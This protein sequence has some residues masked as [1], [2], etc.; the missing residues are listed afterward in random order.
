MITIGECAF[1]QCIGLTS[2]TIPDSVTT[3]GR[4]AFFDDRN[5]NYN[6]SAS[7]S[8]WGAKCVNGYVENG[9]VYTDSTK[10]T[11]VG[12]SASITGSVIIPNG[13]TTISSR[14]FNGCGSLTSVTIP[15]SVT[16]I[17]DY[18]FYA[19]AGLTSITCE[20]TTPP[21]L[22]DVN[23]FYATNNC[24]IY[25]PAASVNRYKTTYPWNS[26]ASRIQAIQS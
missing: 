21:V 20:R 22:S 7:G 16:S 4:G 17:G 26:L 3:I 8:P 14:A 12:V 5:I 10:T 1:Y 23:A 11:L 25:V 24:P 18:A 9:I 19:S 6:G 2:V 15:S 13:V